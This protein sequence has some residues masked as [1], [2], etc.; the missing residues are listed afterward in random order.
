[1]SLPAGDG[2]LVQIMDAALGEARR[3][4]GPHLACRVGCTQCCHGPFRINALDAAR[5]RVGMEALRESDAALA[6][7]I[8]R[9]ARAWVEAWAAEFPGDAATGV[10]TDAEGRSDLR[11]LRM[12]RRVRRWTRER[13]LRRVRVA[14]DDLPRVRAAGADGDWRAWLLRAVLYDGGR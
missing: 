8:E 12:R 5:L 7:E 3:R 10:L 11:S 4:A 6:A 9:R 14:S 13:P 1:M 2:Q